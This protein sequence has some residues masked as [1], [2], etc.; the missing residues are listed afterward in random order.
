MIELAGANYVA[1]V[2]F[3]P[4]SMHKMKPLDVGFYESSEDLL[5]PGY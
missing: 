2:C 4:H 3:P 5:C 1:I